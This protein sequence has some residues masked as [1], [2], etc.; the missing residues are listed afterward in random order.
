MRGSKPRSHLHD[1]DVTGVLN[2]KHH[3]HL[4]ALDMKI[5]KMIY[6]YLNSVTLVRISLISCSIII[7]GRHYYGKERDEK[8]WKANFRCALNSLKTVKPVSKTL[9]GQNAFREYR[10]LD[11]PDTVTDVKPISHG[12]LYNFQHRFWFKIILKCSFE[13]AIKSGFAFYLCHR[14][15]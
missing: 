4:L 7:S 15:L 11:L 12:M 10:F 8:R 5:W 6:H 13:E 3:H 9:K 14:F 1:L 2:S